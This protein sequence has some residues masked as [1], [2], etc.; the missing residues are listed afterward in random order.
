MYTFV[1]LQCIAFKA[2]G[3]CEITKLEVGLSPGTSTQRP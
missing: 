2:M 1:S 3:L